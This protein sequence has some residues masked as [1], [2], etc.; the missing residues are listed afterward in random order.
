MNNIQCVCKKMIKDRPGQTKFCSTRCRNEAYYGRSFE[1]PTEQVCLNCG[2]NFT[3]RTRKKT[4]FCGVKCM[5]EIKIKQNRASIIEKEC[6]ACTVNFMPAQRN[7]VYCSVQCRQQMMKLS[8][9]AGFSVSEIR[10]L[11]LPKQPWRGQGEASL[12][13]PITEPVAPIETPVVPEPSAMEQAKRLEDQVSD[14]KLCER[15]STNPVETVIDAY[16]L[17]CEQ[18]MR[19]VV[20]KQAIA[21]QH[22]RWEKRQ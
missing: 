7:Q 1:K 9:R 2:G 4:R 3:P 15:C 14:I 18:E 22:K 21:E 20:E 17:S 11:P 12:E 5:Y 16:C 8:Y 6:P 13:Q 10:R 19:D